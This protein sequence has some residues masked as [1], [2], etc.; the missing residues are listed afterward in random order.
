[1]EK[2]VA[3][4][5][6]DEVE[7]VWMASMERGATKAA[8]QLKKSKALVDFATRQH[9]ERLEATPE[10][11][12]VEIW[13]MVQEKGTSAA[14]A[15]YG[16]SSRSIAFISSKV[17]NPR[18]YPSMSNDE[19]KQELKYIQQGIERVPGKN[20]AWYKRGELSSAQLMRK[21]NG[22]I[23]GEYAD[24]YRHL[25]KS[26]T[27]A[28]TMDAALSELIQRFL[29]AARR[30]FDNRRWRQ[31]DRHKRMAIEMRENQQRERRRA[32][33]S[34]GAMDCEAA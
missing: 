4:L 9:R 20:E 34:Q 11:S 25:S 14:A 7:G 29:K 3:A 26:V 18:A 6:D 16:L 27:S 13:R 2:Q 33:L 28:P 19:V 10:A 12:K 17:Q 30:T 1:M 24:L 23:A 21:K 22:D 31:S 32:L 8:I 5:S 15:K